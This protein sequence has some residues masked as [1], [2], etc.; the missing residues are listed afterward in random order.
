MAGNEAG[1]VGDLTGHT[2]PELRGLVV[3]LR[4]GEAGDLA[5]G[6]VARATFH[7]DEA[8]CLGRDESLIV[9]SSGEPGA[10]HVQPL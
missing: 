10:D 8:G 2:A 5:S 9:A 4:D 6:V 3:T 7:L 1:S